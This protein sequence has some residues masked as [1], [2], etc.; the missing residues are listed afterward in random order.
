MAKGIKSKTAAGERNKE[1][2]CPP[3]L[4][5]GNPGHWPY[6]CNQRYLIVIIAHESGA[7]TGE[8][9]MKDSQPARFGLSVIL[10]GAI[11]L[12]G[13]SIVPL[14]SA[15]PGQLSPDGPNSPCNGGPHR[16]IGSV[17]PSAP[18]GAAT[19]AY[20]NYGLA[21]EGYSIAPANSGS[22]IGTI[23]SPTPDTWGAIA[24][25]SIGQVYVVG[26]NVSVY[27]PDC[28]GTAN[29]V[30]AI[31]LGRVTL[32]FVRSFGVS[33]IAVDPAGRLYVALTPGNVEDAP[34]PM[35]AVYSPTASGAATPIR[36]LQLTNFY[37]TGVSDIAVDAAENLYVAGYSRDAAN[38]IA[39]YP[40][41]ASG[42]STPSRTIALGN[43]NVY[44]VAADSAGNIFA[45]VCLGCYDGTNFAIEK[46]A[47]GA[48]GEASPIDII[49]L[50]VGSPWTMVGG[51]PVRLDGAGNI[52]AWLVLLGPN[53]GHEGHVLYG[54]GPT[55]S[56]SAVPTVQITLAGG[57]LNYFAVH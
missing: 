37:P 26:S 1:V 11:C 43:D 7:S 51:G 48:D 36:I 18:G 6:A 42:P 13:F 29:P 25:D 35:V 16:H 28:A 20:V 47:P 56:G 9:I 21:I 44:G 15:Q 39:V 41:T 52:F 5:E 54:F 45:S 14:A 17:G 38:V 4:N 27:S 50:T 55:A 34:P 2:C 46:F 31:N 22:L 30:R 40:A 10:S 3:A 12:L 19:V 53:P 33:A 49:N 23:T 8:I 24:T 57:Y 32:F